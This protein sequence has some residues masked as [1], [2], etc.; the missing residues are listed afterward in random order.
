MGKWQVGMRLYLNEKR[1]TAFLFIKIIPVND[2]AIAKCRKCNDIS[3]DCVNCLIP[4]A[5]KGVITFFVVNEL[6]G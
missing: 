5:G 6:K 1:F 2:I 3:L 4:G